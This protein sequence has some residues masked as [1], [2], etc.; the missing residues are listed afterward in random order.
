MRRIRHLGLM[1][2]CLAMAGAATPRPASGGI[3]DLVDSIRGR[4]EPVLL[5]YDLLVPPGEEVALKAS[6]RTGFRL[7]GIEGKRIRFL[8]GEE[9]I[10]QAGTDERGDAAVAWKAPAEPGD[11]RITV[12]VHPE[13][14]PKREAADAELLV[15][16]RPS[17]ARIV[18]VDLDKT[19][20]AS[21][22][23]RVL[24]G[25]AKPM[26]GAGVVLDRLAEDHTVAYL[27][28]RP[29]FLGTSSKQWLARH[30]FPSG[31]VLTSTLGG[32]LSGSGA[33]K[34]ERLSA[35]TQTFRNVV[36]G[37]G[38]KI[39]DVRAY[40]ENN[41]R[42]VLILHV[43]WSE[44]DPED[45]EELADELADL[46]D[47]IHVVTNWSQIADILFHAA[48]HSKQDMEDRLRA[49]ARDLRVHRADDEDD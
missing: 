10:G 42:A 45:Y 38:D 46:P 24:A 47:G 34:A 22:F 23:V 37:I 36:V 21:G 17:D 14:Q 20:V 5:A 15:V 39:S 4:L 12:R 19:V 44:D 25:G 48:T 1:I 41:L 33:Y 29:D 43:D 49:I 13:D 40:A 31:P 27:T 6:L 26:P 8:F 35:L 11:Y 18:I 28:H 9:L 30:R 16:A 3:G 2:A 7:E 32:L